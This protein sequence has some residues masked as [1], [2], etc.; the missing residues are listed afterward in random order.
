[1][2]TN[3][4]EALAQELAEHLDNLKEDD[5]GV[6]I[7][8]PDGN[9]PTM[10]CTIDAVSD[11]AADTGVSQ[12]FTPSASFTVEVGGLVYRVT[13]AEVGPAGGQ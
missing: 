2:R 6:G 11:A 3:I 4:H 5:E 12:V 8:E 13:V 1:M 10:E 7:G 9:H